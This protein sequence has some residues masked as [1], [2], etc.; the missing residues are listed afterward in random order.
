MEENLKSRLARTVIAEEV[1]FDQQ[2]T[3]PPR[4]PDTIQQSE[5]ACSFLPIE[6]EAQMNVQVSVMIVDWRSCY[7][8]FRQ[9]EM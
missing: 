6:K 3:A 7:A 2:M 4:L 9:V 8:L 1:P 5:A